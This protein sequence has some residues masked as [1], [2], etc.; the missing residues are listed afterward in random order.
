VTSCA[1]LVM[2][3]QSGCVGMYEIANGA[4]Y[5]TTTQ[6]HNIR[7]ILT[8]EAVETSSL[9]KYG[10]TC[11]GICH[12]DRYGYFPLGSG[13]VGIGEIGDGALCWTTTRKSVHLLPTTVR[14]GQNNSNAILLRRRVRVSDGGKCP[15]HHASMPTSLVAID[16]DISHDSTTSCLV[17][18]LL[19]TYF[20]PRSSPPLINPTSSASSNPYTSN[21]RTPDAATPH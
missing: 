10:S 5:W 8:S 1:Y 7:R 19:K 17:V 13:W 12:C 6:K 18:L 9:E 21:I 4:L 3:L 16:G 11:V 15:A 2:L 20:P 14:L